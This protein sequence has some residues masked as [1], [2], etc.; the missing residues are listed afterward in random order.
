M[1]ILRAKG[2]KP[3]ERRGKVLFIN[4]DRDYRESRAQNH[5][6]PRDEQKITAAYR[7][8]AD[9]SASPESSPSRNW[10]TT[11]STATSAATPTTPRRPSPRTCGPTST[12][13]CRWR[14]STPPRNCWSEPV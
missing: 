1:L 10:P 14:R 4:A 3:P 9:T 12:A 11:T 13:V 2:A 8:F 6:R 5:L 7:S